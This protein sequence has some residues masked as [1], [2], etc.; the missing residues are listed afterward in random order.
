MLGRYVGMGKLEMVHLKVQILANSDTRWT[1]SGSFRSEN[2][3][4]Y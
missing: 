3:T 2:Y 4:M 1:K